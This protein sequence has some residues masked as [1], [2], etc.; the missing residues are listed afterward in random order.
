VVG[1][2]AVWDVISVL[3]VAVAIAIIV[4][5]VASAA[6]IVPIVVVSTIISSSTSAVVVVIVVAHIA[7]LVLKLRYALVHFVNCCVACG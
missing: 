2:V 6:A 4:I 1:S 5:I 3:P 7:D